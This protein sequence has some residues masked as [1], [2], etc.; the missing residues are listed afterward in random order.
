MSW[1]TSPFQ[2][3]IPTPSWAPPPISAGYMFYGPVAEAMHTDH[4]L[5]ESVEFSS[6]DLIELCRAVIDI[7]A[8]FFL[9]IAFMAACANG[10]VVSKEIIITCITA[11]AVIGSCEAAYRYYLR[12]HFTQEMAPKN[13]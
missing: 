1:F 12:N 7:A 13:D 8:V 9:V 10:F 2:S 4:L 5:Q 6:K 11:G 3:G